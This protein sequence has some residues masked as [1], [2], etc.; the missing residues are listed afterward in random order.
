MQNRRPVA[1]DGA[2]ARQL[3]HQRARHAVTRC[4]TDLQ[5]QTARGPRP[6]IPRLVLIDSAMFHGRDRWENPG[7]TADLRGG[8]C[9]LIKKQTNANQR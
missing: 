7:G 9:D 8:G 6:I 1:T 2:V 4:C 3:P 5:P